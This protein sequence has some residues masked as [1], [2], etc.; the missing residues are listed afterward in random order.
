MAARTVVTPIAVPSAYAGTSPIFTWAPADVSNMNRALSTG[1][2]V[3]LCMNAG[4]TPRAV[5]ITS[6]PDAEQRGGD[7]VITLG[8]NESRVFP[9]FKTAGWIQVDG[10]LWFQGAHTDVEWLV[11]R[12]P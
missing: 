12:L 6:A 3:L 1:R 2:E 10:Y 11:L 5:T 9:F 8:A 4:A 7:I